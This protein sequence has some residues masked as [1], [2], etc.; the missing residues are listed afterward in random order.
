MKFIVINTL[1]EDDDLV[2][3]LEVSHK[4]SFFSR[5]HVG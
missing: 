2:D 1:N 5:E 3:D 4:K